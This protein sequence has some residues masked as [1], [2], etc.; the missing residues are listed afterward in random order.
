[1]AQWLSTL[2][3]LPE[4][5]SSIPRPVLQE[6]LRSPRARA[7]FIYPT[8]ALASDQYKALWPVLEYFGEG[9]ISA[10]VYDGDTTSAERSRIRRS[11][12]IILT[13]PEMINSSFLPNHSKY[14]FDLLFANLQYVVIDELHTYRGAFGSHLA[15]VL[16]RLD[17]VCRYY[18]STPRFLCSSATIA[19]PL[20]L[21]RGICGRQFVQV[22]RDGAPR[23]ERRYVFLQPPKI[24]DIEKIVRH[25][26]ENLQGLSFCVWG[27]SF[28]PE[29]DD[30][31]EA[32]SLVLID[33]LTKRGA[34]IQAYDPKAYEQARFYLKDRLDSITFME[35]KY[36]ALQGC[37]ALVLLTEWREF[38]SPDFGDGR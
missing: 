1:M 34:R 31:R 15:N 38:R 18:H 17:R 14:G 4:V 27:L 29:T 36:S 35:S 12:N 32:S 7:I 2:T 19:N 20:E 30:M 22:K 9:R 24:R 26:G 3:A 6:I 13:N 5:L 11:A 10:G 21:A 23:A 16:R 37:V 25:F 8:K 33:E 28:K